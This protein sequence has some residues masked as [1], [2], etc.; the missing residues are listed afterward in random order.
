MLLLSAG[1]C[2]IAAAVESGFDAVATLGFVS[3]GFATGGLDSAVNVLPLWAWGVGL[4]VFMQV[5]GC[6]RACV[7]VCV[8]LSVCVRLCVLRC[9]GGACVSWRARVRVRVLARAA[10]ARVCVRVCL[11]LCARVCVRVSILRVISRF[12]PVRVT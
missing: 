11:C 8:C 10:P 4:D 2:V 9:G 6:M 5:C 1:L 3:V 12:Q 7:R